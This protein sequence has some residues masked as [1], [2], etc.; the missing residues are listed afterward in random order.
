MKLPLETWDAEGDRPNDVGRAD[1]RRGPRWNRVVGGVLLLTALGFIPGET[2]RSMEV[3]VPWPA[4]LAEAETG[5]QFATRVAGLALAEREA[6]ITEAVLS[7]NVPGWLRTLVA[8]PVSPPVAAETNR[9][10][11]YVAP[12]YLAVG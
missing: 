7:G 12:D 9:L 2:A 6:A 4:R 5:S 8:V 1:L 11:L 10:T 3:K